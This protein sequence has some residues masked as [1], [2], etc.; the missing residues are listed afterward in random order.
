MSQL[1]S[2][3]R[4]LWSFLWGLWWVLLLHPLFR[5]RTPSSVWVIGGHRGR[6]YGDNSAAVEAEARRQGKEI[7]WV[8]NPTLAEQLRAQGIRAVDRHSWKARKAI[9]TA[10]LLIYSHGEDDLDL[11]L[12]LLRQRTAPRVYLDHCMCTLKAGGM[13]DPTLLSTAWPLR[14]VRTWLLTRWD[15]VLCASEEVR[16]NFYQCYPMNPLS[17][18]RARLGGGA[19]LD[20]WQK[21]LES[22]VKRQIYWFPT[23]RETP[24]GRSQLH[25]VIETVTQDARLRDWLERN[26]YRLLI[27]THVNAKEAPPNLSEPFS[28]SPLHSLTED[29]RQS[30]LLISDYSGVVYDFLLLE[31]PQILFAFDLSDYTKR[32]HLF[33]KYEERDFALHPRT[34]EQLVQ[35]LISEAWRDPLLRKRASAHRLRSL[36]QAAQSYAR[37]SVLELCKVQDIISKNPGARTSQSPLD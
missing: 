13:T 1:F 31:R 28:L 9:S 17:P 21:G 4:A 2:L 3:F 25:A 35:M 33:G 16:K 23:F 19:H 18:D 26:S 14:S 22:E 6:H 27:G 20:D 7:V 10:G 29:A 34:P 24:Q 15:Y 37:L 8:A 11:L 36:P 32:R 5:L 12:I 30:E